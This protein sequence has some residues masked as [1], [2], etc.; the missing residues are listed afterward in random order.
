MKSKLL[1]YTF[2]IFAFVFLTLLTQTGGIIF[3]LSIYISRKTKQDF[4]GKRVATFLILYFVFTLLI[5]PFIAPIFGREKVVNTNKIKPTNYISVLLNRNYA[6][7][8]MN[9]VLLAIESDLNKKN[10]TIEIRYLD[11][12]FPYY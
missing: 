3:I 1:K 2:W 10:S 12:N 11:A 6:R 7:P 9:K 4:I 5:I 8:E